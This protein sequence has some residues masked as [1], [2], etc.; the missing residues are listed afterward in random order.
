[1]PR[2]ELAVIFRIMGRE[3]KIE[4]LKDTV[5]YLLGKGYN[6]RKVQSLGDRG[7]PIKM[8][9]PSS[10]MHFT[11]SYVLLDMD[12][13]T[14]DSPEIELFFKSN[15]DVLRMSYLPYDSIYFSEQPCDGMTEVDY[16]AKLEELKTKPIRKTKPTFDR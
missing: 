7:L 15:P 8:Y 1:M 6:V 14:K 4:F 5:K 16:A 12:F 11:G 2:Y 9:T 10:E 3:K 13:K